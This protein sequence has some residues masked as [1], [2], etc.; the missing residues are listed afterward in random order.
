VKIRLMVCALA[1]VILS[2]C[3]GGGSSSSVPSA[4][5]RS[6]GFTTRTI[7]S[8]GQRSS[9]SIAS[10]CANASPIALQAVPPTP[11]SASN[12]SWS[13]GTAV[14]ATEYSENCAAISSTPAYA[15][16]DTGIATT[17][18]PPYLNVPAPAAGSV[19]V[20]GVAA[21]LTSVKATFPDGTSA[22]IPAG[23]YGTMGVSCYSGSTFGV[24]DGI[25]P[26]QN[27][28]AAWSASTGYAPVSDE[29]LL[30]DCDKT[31]T[32]TPPP[33][34]D[35]E[36]M[37]ADDTDGGV[38]FP[39]GYD[40]VATASSLGAQ[41][42]LALQTIGDCSNFLSQGTVLNDSAIPS[43]GVILFKTSAGTCVKFAVQ[44][45]VEQSAINGGS[46]NGHTLI[47]FYAVS[48]A[49]GKFSY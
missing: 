2:A 28:V 1:V 21:G 32:I 45:S 48:E 42:L 27:P 6:V 7:Q 17:S 19:N 31:R 34:P 10:A 30:L 44:E 9:Q 12:W 36:D 38:K 40:V 3:S 25:N 11:L 8:V 43:A 24:Y 5:A 16:L 23:V 39:Y 26:Q 22:T 46:V 49:S 14:T 47:G 33:A 4:S 13:E 29:N 41:P 18:A 20:T 15:I 35:N 37:Q